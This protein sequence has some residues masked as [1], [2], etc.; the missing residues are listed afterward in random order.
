MG[1]VCGND[2]GCW[3]WCLNVVLSETNS[4][5]SA[6]AAG[7]SASGCLRPIDAQRAPPWASM[8]RLGP[9]V[10]DVTGFHPKLPFEWHNWSD[11][12]HSVC[13]MLLDMHTIDRYARGVLRSSGKYGCAQQKMIGF[14][15]NRW[16]C[17][18]MCTKLA[19]V[20]LVCSYCIENLL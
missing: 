9:T 1:A 10:P 13:N 7:Q 4:K 19:E 12:E 15:R 8:S 16:Q 20:R 3:C 11:F 17:C 2:C 18:P 6:G 5:M 14:E